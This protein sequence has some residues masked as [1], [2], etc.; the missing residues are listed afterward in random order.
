MTTLAEI[1]IICSGI[2][3]SGLYCFLKCGFACV[4]AMNALFCRTIVAVF[5]NVLIDILGHKLIKYFVLTH[6]L[7]I[8]DVSNGAI[9]AL[10]L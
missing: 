9:E 1:A 2:D 8:H 4:N 3:G 6:C 7:L 10:W 5:I